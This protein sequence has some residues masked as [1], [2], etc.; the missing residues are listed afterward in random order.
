MLL[1]RYP[2]YGFGSSKQALPIVSVS[3]IHDTLSPQW[4]NRIW[5]KW[6]R[7][8]PQIAY[9]AWFPRSL[10]RRWDNYAFRW[11]EGTEFWELGR[12]AKNQSGNQDG[13]IILVRGESLVKIRGASRNILVLVLKEK[14]YN[15]EKR[16]S[17]TCKK[18]LAVVDRFK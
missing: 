6:I 5:G 18:S 3:W 1:A 4:R 8:G 14:I 12:L 17:Y 9:I 16:I 2:N 13:I 15:H 7:S 10:T 11:Y